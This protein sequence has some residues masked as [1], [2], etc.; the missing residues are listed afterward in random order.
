MNW[1]GTWLAVR[2]E[3]LRCIRFWLNSLLTPRVVER[4]AISELEPLHRYALIC[5]HAMGRRA[6]HTRWYTSQM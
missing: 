5:R 4:S 3:S 1:C 6:G 2:M